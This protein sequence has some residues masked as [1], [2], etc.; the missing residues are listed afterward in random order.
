MSTECERGFD[1]FYYGM[2]RAGRKGGKGNSILWTTRLLVWSEKGKGK[3][4]GPEPRLITSLSPRAQD[5]QT[6]APSFYPPS[7]KWAGGKG[8]LMSITRKKILFSSN[9]FFSTKPRVKVW[10]TPSPQS[11]EIVSPL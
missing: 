8:G 4:Y 10:E 7:I 2:R 3:E 11:R 9:L 5:T 6:E 1:R